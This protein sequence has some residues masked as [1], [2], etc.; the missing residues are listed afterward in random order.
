VK[1]TVLRILILAPLLTGFSLLTAAPAAATAPL[2]CPAGQVPNWNNTVCMAPQA[3]YSLS[4]YG[5]PTQQKAVA[6]G[7]VNSSPAMQRCNGIPVPF[8]VPCSAA[9]PSV[10]TQSISTTV[11]ANNAANAAAATA[12][13]TAAAQAKQPSIVVVAGG[14]PGSGTVTDTVSTGTDSTAALES[15]MGDWYTGWIQYLAATLNFNIDNLQQISLT[16]SRLPPCF[17]SQAS[18]CESAIWGILS[19]WVGPATGGS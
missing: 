5:L 16:F 3:P 1:V 6:S 4:G 8:G 18:A 12:A 10:I 17:A 9:S 7:A 15:L 13:A 14:P 19:Q 2:Q 11:A